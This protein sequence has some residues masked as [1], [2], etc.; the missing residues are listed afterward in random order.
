MNQSST[1]WQMNEPAGMETTQPILLPAPPQKIFYGW[2]VVTGAFI[3]MFMGF[4]AA[5]SFG[6]FFHALRDEFGATRREVSLVF[7]LTAFLYFLLGAFSGPVADRIGP[8]RVIAT[9]GVCVASGLLL[10][11]TTQHLWQVYAT[12]SLGVGVGV[13][14]AYVPSVGAVQ[15]WFTRQRGIASGLA[16]AGIGLGTLLMPPIAAVLIPR[17]GW[18]WTYAILG[19]V[20][21]LIMVPASLLIEH[22]PEARGLTPNGDPPPPQQSATTLGGATLQEALWSPTFWW[23]YLAAGTTAL[24]LFIPFVHIVP[25]ATDHGLSE[26]AGSMILG[27]IGAGSTLGRLVLGG[28]ADR[29]GRRQALVGAFLLM[30][31]M[32]VWWLGSTSLWSLLVFALCFGTGYGGFVALIPALTVDYF[33]VRQA[34]AIIGSLYTS[35]GVGSLVG[36]TLAGVVFDWYQSYTLPI[37]VSAAANLVAVCCLMVLG[38]K[39]YQERVARNA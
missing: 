12:Y 33:G 17:F 22:S 39:S 7:S 11:A 29:F 23:L 25:Y 20:V 16:V 9:G 26:F 28:T 34:G 21:L 14:I 19:I 24:G 36:P 35:V 4:G 5:Y 6:P 10:A 3:V 15:R 32:Q 30:T 18:R 37:L 1:I 38:N 13:G 8:R 31:L 27:T 2:W